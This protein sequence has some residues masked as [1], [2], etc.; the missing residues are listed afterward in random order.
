MSISTTETVDI[1]DTNVN[2]KNVESDD[3][4]NETDTDDNEDESNENDKNNYRSLDDQTCN[5]NDARQSTLGQNSADKNSNDCT[6]DCEILDDREKLSIAVEKLAC[7]DGKYFE[8]IIDQSSLTGKVIANCK[9]CDP[10]KPFK[11]SLRSTLNFTSH[12]K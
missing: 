1:P 11:G 10:P 3:E 8:V 4:D 5:N 9:L 6:N 7:L 2:N 12:L